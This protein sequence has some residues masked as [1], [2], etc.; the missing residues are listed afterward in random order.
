MFNDGILITFD[1]SKNT[2]TNIYNLSKTTF[3]DLDKKYVDKSG[4][5]RGEGM[6]LS[7]H[8]VK[9]G[10]LDLVLDS[11]EEAEGFVTNVGQVNLFNAT[12]AQVPTSRAE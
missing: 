9:F 12:E 1:P 11:R 8:C 7:V 5:P 4:A 10:R 2:T 6:A 3:A